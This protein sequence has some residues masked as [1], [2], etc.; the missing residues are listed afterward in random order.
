MPVI[1]ID[2]LFLIN[3][4]LDSGL[5][6]ITSRLSGKN[7]HS[8]RILLGGVLG[9]IYA[10][11]IFFVA[12][13][14]WS[15]FIIKIFITGLMIFAAFF[16]FSKKEFLRFIINFYIQ[17]FLLGGTLSAFFYF[18]GR[19]AVMSNSIYYFPFSTLQLLFIALPLIGA[20][21][22]YWKKSKN[23]LL[24]YGKHCTVSIFH[25]NKYLSIEGLIDSGCSLY[26]P[27]SGNPVIILSTSF[28]KKLFDEKSAEL[29]K[30]NEIISLLASG[31]F[32]IIPFS[33]ISTRDGNMPA[34]LPDRC[35]IKTDKKVFDCSCVIA[36]S[37]FSGKNAIINP[38]VFNFGGK[39]YEL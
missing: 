16:P 27:L 8:L 31:N 26:D 39:S 15:S 1:Y 7:T 21:Y 20:L 3:F 25:S 13:P 29:I 12:L 35:T 5:L 36:F 10:C 28:S 17:S 38:D 33:T 37:S 6:L 9:G 14:V 32:R 30:N 22:F 2:V 24:S 11:S 34:F 4:I 23:R 19:P 18:S